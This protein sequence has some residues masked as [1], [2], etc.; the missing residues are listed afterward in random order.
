M[1]VGMA[2]VAHA[3]DKATA[4]AAFDRAM[5][6]VAGGNY[7]DACPLFDASYRADPELGVL[8]HLADCHE[9]IGR[10][11]SAWAEFRDAAELARKSGDRREAL[12][13]G[14]AAALAPKLPR[15]HIAPPTTPIPGLVVL[16]D[17]TDI[18]L[19]ISSDLPVDPG[20]HVLVA[21]APG[22]EEWKST[23]NVSAGTTP[24]EVPPLAES[25]PPAAPTPPVAHIETTTQ[26]EPPLPEPK[27][28]APQPAPAAPEPTTKPAP[29]PVDV[30]VTV[31]RPTTTELSPLKTEGVVTLVGAGVLALGG[32]YFGYQARSEWQDAQP[33]CDSMTC[34]TVGLPLARDA[35]SQADVSTKLFIAS[36]LVAG[37]GL[38]M[39]LLAPDAD[40]SEQVGHPRVTPAVTPSAA[41]LVVSGTF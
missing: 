7:R 14:R 35:G 31:P 32:L 18:S 38:A 29:V 4:E 39:I 33:H 5:Q 23:M 12:A 34:D 8:L 41:S 19:L 17:G 9:H 20:D 13:Q 28:V 27:V 10:V 1:L 2:G 36:G 6:L 40:S 26:P 16:L 21:H 37:G 22:R 30:A 24:I 25:P 15:L 11:A 3:E